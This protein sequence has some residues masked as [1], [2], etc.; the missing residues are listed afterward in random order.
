[1]ENGLLVVGYG[2]PGNWIMFSK[3]EGTSWGP[4]IPFHHGL[5]PPDCSNYFSLAEVAPNILLV[6]YA[7][8]NPNDHWQSEL[9]GTY[10]YVERE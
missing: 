1:M 6:V 9:V 4:I 5:Y 8:T 7:R 10:F 3:D 2:R